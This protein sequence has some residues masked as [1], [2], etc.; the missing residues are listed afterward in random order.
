MV[1]VVPAVPFMPSPVNVATPSVGVT[2]AVP[3]NVPPE[4]IVAVTEFEADV[5]V[6]LRAS[7]NVIDGEVVNVAPAVV[8]TAGCVSAIDVALPAPPATVCESVVQPRDAAFTSV[9]LNV[10]V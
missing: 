3:S 5:T 1:Y 6:L 8:P 2:V 7:R 4:L 9:A 10:S